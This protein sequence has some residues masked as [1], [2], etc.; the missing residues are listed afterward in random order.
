[1]RQTGPRARRGRNGTWEHSF[2]REGRSDKP[3]GVNICAANS[4]C[5]GVKLGLVT[6][7]DRMMQ[8]HRGVVSLRGLAQFAGGTKAIGGAADM[9]RAKSGV[10]RHTLRS[11]RQA[12]ALA[13]HAKTGFVEAKSDLIVGRLA[14][15]R[16]LKNPQSGDSR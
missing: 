16:I 6:E 9:R 13:R 5:N 7:K 15:A 11:Q 1:R 8:Q 14:L 10:H 3:V 2:R 12:K 4:A